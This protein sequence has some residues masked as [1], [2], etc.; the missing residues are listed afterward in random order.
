MYKLW[1]KKQT[2]N[3]PNIVYDIIQFGS[4]TESEDYNDID[5]AI[6]FKNTPIK[7]QLEEAQKIKRQL[8]KITEKKID[9]KTYDLY[10]FFEPNNFAKNNILLQGKSL[11]TNNSFSEK[12]GLTPKT[13]ISYEL[14][15]LEKK[16]KIRFHYLLQGKKETQGLLQKEGGKLINPGLIEIPP[17]KT[18]IFLEK[19]KKIT[20]KIKTKNILEIN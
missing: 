16:E 4:S 18:K 10:N 1:Q 8:E 15:D 9:I 13:Q 7:K 12:L 20:N 3:Y 2:L 14:K 6:I 11:I 19:M 17:E 5:I